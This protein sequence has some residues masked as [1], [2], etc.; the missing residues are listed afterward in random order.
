[1]SESSI[2]AL[3]ADPV[4]DRDRLHSAGQS[5]GVVVVSGIRLWHPL[6]SGR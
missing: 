4:S 2:H 3:G 5:R 6:R 1:M